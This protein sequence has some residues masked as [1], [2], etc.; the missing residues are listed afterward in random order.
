MGENRDNILNLCYW[1][2]EKILEILLKD[3]GNYED[4][5]LKTLGTNF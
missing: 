1:G 4:M 2:D 3:P 5:F